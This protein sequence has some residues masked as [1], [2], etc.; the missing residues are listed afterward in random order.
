MEV[1]ISFFEIKLHDDK[2]AAGAAWP[3]SIVDVQR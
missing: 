2:I 1:S 3:I